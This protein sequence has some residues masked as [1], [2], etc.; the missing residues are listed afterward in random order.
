MSFLLR[1]VE[2]CCHRLK[3]LK[4]LKF[5]LFILLLHWS[6]NTSYVKLTMKIINRNQLCIR[7][8][9]WKCVN[10]RLSSD[11]C[12]KKLWRC[13]KL[14]VLTDVMIHKQQQDIEKGLLT[15]AIQIGLRK[16]FPAYLA[17]APSSSSILRSWL[18]LARRSDLQGA[19]VLIWP[20]QRPTARSAM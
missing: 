2:S 3:G 5:R 14:Y 4:R 6:K 16:L 19:P 8:W 10:Y 11:V 15:Y 1:F 20:V 9:Y 18:Y 7:R 17:L 12:H 13:W